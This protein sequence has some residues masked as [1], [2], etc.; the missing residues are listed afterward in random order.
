MCWARSYVSWSVCVCPGVGR[1]PESCSSA[2]SS[3][4]PLWVPSAAHCTLLSTADMNSH[5]WCQTGGLVT[6]LRGKTVLPEILLLIALW[7]KKTNLIFF[8][9][10]CIYRLSD[11]K[12]K[13]NVTSSMNYSCKVQ[14]TQKKARSFS[15]TNDSFGGFFVF[16]INNRHWRHKLLK[17]NLS[18]TFG[19]SYAC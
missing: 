1:K 17:V 8:F 13:T 11:V 16:F 15:D 2:L 4:M 18:L 12:L 19:S 14:C 5:K 6:F 10:C 7:A 3:P 9:L